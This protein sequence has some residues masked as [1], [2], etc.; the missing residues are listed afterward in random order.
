MANHHQLVLKNK[1][2]SLMSHYG[3]EVEVQ[4]IKS[5][6]GPPPLLYRQY[7]HLLL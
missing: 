6:G 7:L 3:V 5:G 4:Q 2:V 1:Y